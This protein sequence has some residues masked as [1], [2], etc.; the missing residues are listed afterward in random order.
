MSD[1][2]YPATRQSTNKKVLKP[3]REYQFEVFKVTASIILFAI[4]YV[5]LVLLAVGLAGIVSYFGLMLLI[6][7]PMFITLMLGAGMIGLG[8]MV[9]YFLVKFIFT[10]KKIDRS[11]FYE[12]KEHD[13]PNLYSFIKKLTKETETPMPKRIYLSPDVNASV[14]YDSNFF[15]MFFPV[16][17]NLLIGLGLVNS[18]NMSEFKAVI[19]HEFGHFSQHSMKLGSYVFNLNK[20]IYN[21]LYDNE[22]YAATIDKWASASGYFALFANLT[23]KIVQGIQWI[24]KKVYIIINKSNLSLSRQMEHHADAVSAYATGP[25]HLILALKRLEIADTC[26][27][28]LLSNY[29]KWIAENIKPDNLLEQHREV[30]LHFAV[31]N[32][33]ELENGLP[34]V[35][36]PA[37]ANTNIQSRIIVKD[38]WASHPGTSERETY[39][40]SLNL[41]N[42]DTVYDSPW[43]LFTDPVTIQKKITDLLFSVVHYKEK[44]SLLDLSSFKERYYGE[45]NRNAYNKEFKGFYNNRRIEAFNPDKIKADLNLKYTQFVDLYSNENCKLP[46][47]LEVVTADINLL[48]AIHS[49]QYDIKTFDFNGNKCSKRDIPEILKQLETEEA[50]LKEQIID[51]DKEVF[52][53]FISKAPQLIRKEI[54]EL[55]NRYFTASKDAEVIVNEYSTLSSTIRPIYNNIPLEE[56]RRIIN[57]VKSIERQIIL[58]IVDLIPDAKAHKY[59]AQSQFE[60]IDHYLSE[61]RAYFNGKEF[62]TDELKLFTEAIDLIIS[63]IIEREFQLKRELLQKQL[64][65][66]N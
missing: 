56:A 13:F 28:I 50:I 29:N 63:L 16:K 33:F 49:K 12:I 58:R 22:G 17:K 6:F 53:F 32:G 35:N 34:V 54:I 45:F 51:L 10:I 15:S 60:K 66:L 61:N 4:V 3:T 7:K 65:V 14:F 31:E 23:I 62:N 8:L 11:G 2:I 57:E 44:I 41:E 19:A 27:N 59:L 9:I 18:V 39:L 40:Q 30:I 42:T 48:K 55:Y 36:N 5:L 21:M 46:K 38:Q 24:L 20:I 26:Y 1:F 37:S 52:K 25:N 64:E 47:E 43:T